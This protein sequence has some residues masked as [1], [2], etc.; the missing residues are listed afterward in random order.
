MTKKASNIKSQISARQTFDPG[1]FEQ[2]L[3]EPIST[4]I[5]LIRVISGEIHD[6]INKI[7]NSKIKLRLTQK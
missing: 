1:G 5:N 3:T 7:T 6:I 4:P 2:F